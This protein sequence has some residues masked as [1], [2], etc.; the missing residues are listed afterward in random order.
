MSA[1]TAG[2]NIE[3]EG[4][5]SSV[6]TAALSQ[7]SSRVSI[8]YLSWPDGVK[9]DVHN[10]L[11]RGFVTSNQAPKPENKG[12]A[13]GFGKLCDKARS[14]SS[15]EWAGV[16]DVSSHSQLVERSLK[17]KSP[18]SSVLCID[19]CSLSSFSVH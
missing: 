7:V 8:Y 6:L 13:A 2:A 18:S 4:G 5:P 3:I 19:R 17:S 16:Q 14:H 12:I 15:P 1:L 11:Q 10:S 9:V